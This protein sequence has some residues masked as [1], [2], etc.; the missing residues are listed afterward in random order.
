MNRATFVRRG[1]ATLSVVLAFSLL[2]SAC[3]GS[4][5]AGTG[6]TLTGV[7]LVDFEQSAIDNLALNQ[8]LTFVFSSPVDPNSISPGSLQIR[9]GPNYGQS[10]PGQ[11]VIDGE[12][13]RFEP[14][15]PSLCDL[16]D[17]GLHPDTDYRAVLLGS[18]EEFSI[19]NLAGTPL[20][21]TIFEAFHTRDDTQGSL[22]EDPL[23]GIGPVVLTTSPANG[24]AS[25]MVEDDSDPQNVI[26]GKVVITFSENLDPCTLTESTVLFYQYAVGD[27]VNSFVPALDQTPGDPYTW[28]SGTPTSPARRVRSQFVLSQ[29]FLQTTLEIRPY[30]DEFPDNALLVVTLTSGVKDYGGLALTPLSFSFTTENRPQQVRETRFEFDGDVPVNINVSTG[31]ANTLRSPSRAQGWLLF[32]GDGDNGLAANLRLPSGPDNSRG[33]PGC[34][35]PYNGSQAQNDGLQDDFDTSGQTDV[36][37]DTGS[38]TNTCFNG[39]DGSTAVIFEYRTF[40]IRAGATVRLVGRNPAIILVQGNAVIESGG[41]LLVRGDGSGGAPQSDGQ[42]GAK[43]NNTTPPASLPGGTGV[44]G[45][46][47]G[48]TSVTT[49]TIGYG[50]NGIQGYFL[51]GGGFVDPTVGTTNGPG[52]GQGNISCQWKQQVQT[53]NRNGTS[54]GGGG[55]VD[56]GQDG[57]A[58]PNDNSSNPVQLDGTP[59][60]VGGLA[61]GEVTGRMSTAE[62]GS[63]GGAGGEIRPFTSNVG[64]ASGG[65]GGAGGGFVDITARGDIQVFGTIDASGGRGG[66]GAQGNYY[67]W[68]PGSGGGGGGSGGGVR[69]LT[70]GQIFFTSTTTVRVAGGAGGAGGLS[71]NPPTPPVANNG[72]MGSNG[73]LVIEDTDSIVNTG[74]STLVPAEGQPGFYRSVFDVS[75]FKGGGLVNV[76]ETDLMDSGPFF[77]TYVP[78]DQDYAVPTPAPAPSTP[79]RDFFAG[80]PAGASRGIGKTGIFLEMKA[81]LAN[82]DGSVNTGSDSGWRSV[83]YFSDSGAETQPVW[84]GGVKPP[85]GDVTP[86]PGNV[87]DGIGALSGRQFYKLRFTFYLR[88]GMG[89]FD[90]GPYIDWWRFYVV[91]DQ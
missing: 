10:V 22:Y 83:G 34:A 51:T 53:A 31:D 11:F 65:S 67:T 58:L 17:A 28:G 7:V 44:A 1:G 59:D 29:D 3:G 78:P 37:L 16:S 9:E 61:Y 52:S 81:F 42:N 64:R 32:A 48:G 63:G 38:T 5:G 72:G 2:V 8:V 4:G 45:G 19:R 87:G 57:T 54:G 21:A 18:P 30:F 86:L 20:Q 91:Y 12:T 40:R 75:R 27:P 73:R 47:N 89:P 60:G 55:H 43:Y 82:A 41:R 24:S 77:P 66:A 49:N 23:P 68:E 36:V 6:E 13:V 80:I 90:P 84:N 35:A 14:R 33:P 76:I 74:T 69:L 70:P 56:I 71:N 26:P 39:T 46:G 50:G 85:A 79:R 15:L 88:N 62:T 25:V